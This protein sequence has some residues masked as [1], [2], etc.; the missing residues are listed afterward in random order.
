M[1][2]KYINEKIKEILYNNGISMINSEE[3]FLLDSIS[4]VSV[5]VDIE[6]TF[7]ICVPPEKIVPKSDINLG[8]FVNMVAEILNISDD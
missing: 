4:Y 1:N 7:K 5:I 6:T 2:S 8:F 3:K